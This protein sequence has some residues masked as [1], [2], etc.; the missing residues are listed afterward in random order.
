MNLSSSFLSTCSVTWFESQKVGSATRQPL[1]SLPDT[2]RQA[3]GFTL[4]DFR[5]DDDRFH[6]LTK[7]PHPP[8][9]EA[10][11]QY[12]IVFFCSARRRVESYPVRP[13]ATEPPAITAVG[14]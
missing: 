10:R 3:A 1:W 2:S 9:S 8:Q 12:C 4:E 14:G 5:C 6:F 11:Y 7:E 13:A